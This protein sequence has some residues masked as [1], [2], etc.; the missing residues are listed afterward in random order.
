MAKKHLKILKNNGIAYLINGGVFA[1]AMH[2]L[3]PPYY[4]VCV[5]L[6][7]FGLLITYL[8]FPKQKYAKHNIVKLSASYAITNISGLVL[9]CLFMQNTI[10]FWD[11]LRWFEILY[12]LALCIIQLL[13]TKVKYNSLSAQEY[14]K[15]QAK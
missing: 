1:L 7:I 10:L 11:G 14:E 4:E 13:I 6:L 15:K 3:K 5:G 8:T 2:F 12:V 9:A